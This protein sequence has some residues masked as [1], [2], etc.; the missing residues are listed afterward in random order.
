MAM[1]QRIKDRFAPKLAVDGFWGP[2]SQSTCQ[3]Y[4]RAMMPETHPWPKSGAAALTKFFGKAGD[5]GALVKIDFPYPMF[6]GGKIVRA[7]RCHEKVA[8]SLLRVLTT[9]GKSYGTRREIMEPAEDYGG[10]YNYRNK[11]GA[12][13][14]S[15]HA[16]GIAI[17]L[18]ADDNSFRDQWPL[19]ADMP[20]EVMEVFSSEGWKCA[21]AWWGYDAMHQQCTQ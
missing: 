8:A 12:T 2:V 18:D 11:R 3:R 4:L 21:G 13:T 19:R 10:I 16:L 7:S 14:L 9:L 15:C 20:L 17:D 1:Q 6:Y 5:E